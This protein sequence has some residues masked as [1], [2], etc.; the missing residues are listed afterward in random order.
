MKTR[1]DKVTE[2]EL[3]NLSKKGSRSLPELNINDLEEKEKEK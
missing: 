2:V 3:Q 1:Q